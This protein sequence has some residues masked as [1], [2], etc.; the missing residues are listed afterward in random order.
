MDAPQIV[1]GLGGADRS[2]EVGPC[3]ARLRTEDLLG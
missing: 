2:V 3:T 1:V